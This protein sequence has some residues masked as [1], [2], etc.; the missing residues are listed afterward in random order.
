MKCFFFFFFFI[1]SLT[2]IQRYNKNHFSFDPVQEQETNGNF[3]GCHFMIIYQFIKTFL[4]NKMSIFEEYGAFKDCQ[5]FNAELYV[6]HTLLFSFV[7]LF[8]YQP[9][10]IG[11]VRLIDTDQPAHLV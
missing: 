9:S 8:L 1:V 7:I 5:M 11:H 2:L 10:F 4:D 3:T 6:I